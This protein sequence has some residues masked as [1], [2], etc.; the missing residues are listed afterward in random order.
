MLFVDCEYV[1]SAAFP[2]KRAGDAINRKGVG[3]KK[4]RIQASMT[5]EAVFLV[6]LYL[7][8]CLS[9]LFIMQMLHMEQ[10]I[11]HVLSRTS[12]EVALYIP[13]EGMLKY[14]SAELVNAENAEYVSDDGTKGRGDSKHQS[15]DYGIAETVLS[16][17][18]A[19]SALA[20]SLPD[21]YR[22]QCG[23]DGDISLLVASMVDDSEV[24]DLKAGYVMKPL[25]NVFGIPDVIIMTRARTRAWT[26]YHVTGA[27]SDADDADRIVY[28]TD[29]SEVYHLSRSCTHLDLSIT[30]VNADDIGDH[31]NIGGGHYS[32][33]ERC[34]HGESSGI[35]FITNEGDRYHTDIS[36]SGLKR[37]IYE[38]LLSEVGDKRVCSRCAQRY[39]N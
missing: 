32:A 31:V 4:D 13:A 28:V 12:K 29:G 6:P 18:Y 7:F 9:L 38:I 36:C 3:V 26:G 25:A 5:I 24:V 1:C 11:D 27:E 30:P 20:D 10:S 2:Q 19:S 17:G 16:W 37:T 39:G 14:D 34:G 33:C 23:L 21:D 15:V 22:K 8:F 35:Y